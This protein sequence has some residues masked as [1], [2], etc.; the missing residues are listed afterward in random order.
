MVTNNVTINQAAK[1]KHRTANSMVG[2]GR[3][4][5]LN[6]TAS[7]S[8][9]DFGFYNAAAMKCSRQSFA[10]KEILQL[11]VCVAYFII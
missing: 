5:F 10:G 7:Q 3:P 4:L 9:S 8:E 11:S 2:N 1:L 6:R